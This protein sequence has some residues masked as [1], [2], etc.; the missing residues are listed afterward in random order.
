[1]FTLKQLKDAHSKVKTGADFPLYIKEIKALGLISYEFMVSDGS[2]IYHGEQDFKISSAPIYEMLSINPESS[3]E[4]IQRSISIHQQGKTD[5]ITFCNEAAEAGVEKWVIDTE[6]MVCT[7][8][9]AKGVT[10]V[11]EPIPSA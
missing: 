1:M 10:L 5:L 4:L 7:Y 6:H 9:D 3:S 11:A 2:I 8:Y